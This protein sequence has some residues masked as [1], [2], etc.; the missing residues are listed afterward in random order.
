MSAQGAPDLQSRMV[1]Q[2]YL[3]GLE[4][5]AVAPAI[6]TRTLHS[7]KGRASRREEKPWV[8]VG[9]SQLFLRET[10][11]FAL[12]RKHWRAVPQECPRMYRP[13]APG[14]RFDLLERFIGGFVG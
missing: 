10:G 12:F 1:Q 11:R 9:V 3:C 13:Q 4:E 5:I 14:R 6:S 2:V 8:D 7:K